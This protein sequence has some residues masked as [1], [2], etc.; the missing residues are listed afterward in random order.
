MRDLN[1]IYYIKRPGLLEVWKCLLHL[2]AFIASKEGL[3]SNYLIGYVTKI[4]EDKWQAYL[5]A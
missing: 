3:H 4:F 5:C 1:L 2:K